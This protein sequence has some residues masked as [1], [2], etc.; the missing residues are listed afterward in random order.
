MGKYMP[1]IGFKMSHRKIPHLKFCRF[2]TQSVS[3]TMGKLLF[4]QF[5]VA[6]PFPLLTMLRNNEQNLLQAM[7]SVHNIV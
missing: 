7:L 3:Q 5:F 1:S 4:E 6:F 2:F